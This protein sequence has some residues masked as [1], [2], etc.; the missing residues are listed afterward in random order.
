MFALASLALA[1]VPGPGGALH[2]RAE[3]PP[4]DAG[5]AR[6]GPRGLDAAALL[7]VLAAVIGLSA[8]ARRI[9]RGVHRRQAPR[10]PLYLVV[11]R[12]PDA[13]ERGRPRDRGRGA[14]ERTLARTYRRGRRRQRAQ[15]EDR[16]LLPRLPAAVRRPR[17]VDARPAGGPR[18]DLRAD[19]ADERPRLGARRRARPARCSG[20]AGRSCGSSATS[21]GRSSSASAPSPR[22]PA[23]RTDRTKASGAA[24]GQRR[25]SRRRRSRSA[26]RASP[27]RP[28]GSPP[29]AARRA[30]IA[31]G[32]AA[33]SR[34]STSSVESSMHELLLERPR[35]AAAAEVPAVELLQEPAR[36]AL[37]QLAHGLA[38]EEHELRDDLLPRRLAPLAVDDLLAAPTGCPG[39]ARPTITAAAPVVA[40]T[41]CARAAGGDVAGGDHRHVDERR[42]ARR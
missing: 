41:A 24:A 36:A 6:L 40:S 15:P 14:A 27:R 22:P 28:P 18:R 32:A 29:R 4:A 10:A 1:V 42:R 19:R 23:A 30:S 39:R 21:R 33:N 5:R 2:R 13:P 12:D 17:R 20:R 7:H 31:P 8:L 34:R 38:D 25:L 11:A 37:A 3:R 35:E 9:R 16:A 26:A